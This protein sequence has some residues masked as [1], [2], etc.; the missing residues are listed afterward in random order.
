MVIAGLSLNLN[1]VA[2]VGSSIG[3]R[4]SAEFQTRVG[5]K[6]DFF[7]NGGIVYT[8]GLFVLGS[9]RDGLQDSGRP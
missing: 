7:W 4:G 5:K 6:S 9:G 3:A 1:G 8:I 2:E